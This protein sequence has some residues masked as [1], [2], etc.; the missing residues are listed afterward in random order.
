MAAEVCPEIH[1]RKNEDEITITGCYGPAGVVVLPDEIKGL[2]VTAIEAYAFAEEAEEPESC[3][4]L[5]EQADYISDRPRIGGDNLS[6]LHL[7]RG[8]R[9]L[10]RYAFYRCS[11]LS[12][13]VMGNALLD[14]GGGA[15]TGCRSVRE[16]EIFFTGDAKSALRSLVSEER[17]TIHARLHYPDGEADVLFPEHYEEAEENTPARILYTVHHGSGGYYRQC[18]YDRELDFKKYDELLPYA[19]AEDH[20]ETVVQLAL[21]RLRF[22]YHL[23]ASAGADYLD[24]LRQEIVAAAV[25]LAGKEDVESIRYLGRMGLWTKEAVEAGIDLASEEKKTGIL[26]V[27]MEEKRKSGFSSK[28]TFQL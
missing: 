23:R 16:V 12:R 3:V 2:P 22:P 18:F 19:V 17:Y 26:S 28:K 20:P 4:Y 10:G 5:T 11:A 1:Y 13:L 7:S 9:Q 21:G 27:F 24:Y 8:I 25:Y 6:E 15:L 14:I